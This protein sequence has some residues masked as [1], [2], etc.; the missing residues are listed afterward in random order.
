[1]GYLILILDLFVND[2][3]N[4]IFNVPLHFFILL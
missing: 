2:F 4:Y 1:M 3:N